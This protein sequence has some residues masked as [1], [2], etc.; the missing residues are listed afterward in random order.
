M[1]KTVVRWWRVWKIQVLRRELDALHLEQL[2]GLQRNR[3]QAH[4]VALL[5]VSQEIEKLRKLNAQGT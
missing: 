1:W 4:G 2:A 5:T 3:V